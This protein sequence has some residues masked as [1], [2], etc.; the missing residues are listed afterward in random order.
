MHCS[1]ARISAHFRIFTLFDRS[2][3][4]IH[5]DMDD[6][7]LRSRTGHDLAGARGLVERLCRVIGVRLV[8]SGY[9]DTH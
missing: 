3:E 5:V 2:V 6:L 7:A 8:Q 4:R 1:S 9:L